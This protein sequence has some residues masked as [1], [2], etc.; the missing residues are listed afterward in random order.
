MKGRFCPKCGATDKPFHGG[1]CL[2]CFLEDHPGLVDAEDVTVKKCMHCLRVKSRGEWENGSPES[3][4]GIIRSH[5]KTSLE[6]AEI[7]LDLLKQTQKEE[8]YDVTVKGVIGSEEV[9]ITKPITLKYEKETCGV[10]SRK[11]GD[12]YEAIIQLRPKE[13]EIDLQRLKSAL[14]FLRNE[15]HA[16]VKKDRKAE[17]FRHE[18]TKNGIDI[19]FGSKRAAKIS[20][21]HMQA[22]YHPVVKESYTLRGV[23]KETGKNRYSVTYSVR[24]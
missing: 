22:T 16:L 13:R 6:D 2:D 14:N 1:F 15:A 5:I 24:L 20:L 7:T 23:D 18:L 9:S 3:V 12:Y 10:C 4:E 8:E 17:I 21:Q 19:Y 11:S